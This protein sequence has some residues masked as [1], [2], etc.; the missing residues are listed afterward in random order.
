MFVLTCASWGYRKLNSTRGMVGQIFHVE[1]FVRTALA[2]CRLKVIF[3]LR[4]PTF[5]CWSE[6]QAPFKASGNALRFHRYLLGTI[7]VMA[8]PL[9]WR[10]MKRNISTTNI[11]FRT[12]LCCPNCNWKQLNEFKRLFRY[13]VTGLY[14]CGI[15]IFTLREWP[16][17]FCTLTGNEHVWVEQ[18]AGTFV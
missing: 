18:S 6:W 14:M 10:V 5:Q 16:L 1:R 12:I 9:R 8:W 11:Y 13:P 17:L 2:S 3:L 7:L 4:K 15:R